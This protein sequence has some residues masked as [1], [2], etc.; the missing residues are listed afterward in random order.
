MASSSASLSPWIAGSLPAG[1]GGA[2]Q[3]YPAG[4]Y[5][6]GAGG[7]GGSGGPFRSPSGLPRPSSPAGPLGGSLVFGSGASSGGAG[8]NRPSFDS[9]TA[10]S[11]GERS[12]PRRRLLQHSRW[13]TCT[14]SAVRILRV[15][16]A[17]VQDC[18]A[19]HC[20]DRF[21]GSFASSVEHRPHFCAFYH[22]VVR[23]MY[24]RIRLMPWPGRTAGM[25][26][27]GISR[28]MTPPPPPFVQPSSS[29]SA[30]LAGS[31]SG[32]LG[33]TGSGQPASGNGGP[34]TGAA[35]IGSVD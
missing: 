32:V 20:H 25:G 8:S 16:Y 24:V 31:S 2:Q 14:Q 3:G 12:A 22:V 11:T 10:A 4:L 7:G 30:V 26:I 29:P 18:G 17:G 19:V 33:G 15:M 21:S 28:G 27:S 5:A 35:P 1:G 13:S 23:E 6:G 9:S 34:F